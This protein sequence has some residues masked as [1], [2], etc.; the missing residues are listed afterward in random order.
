[1]GL[2]ALLERMERLRELVRMYL[3]PKPPPLGSQYVKPGT[4][5][6][7]IVMPPDPAQPSAFLFLQVPVGWFRVSAGTELEAGDIEYDFHTKK[8]VR[9]RAYVIPPGSSVGQVTASTFIIRRYHRPPNL[10]RFRAREVGEL[11]LEGDYQW[12]ETGWHFVEAPFAV[13]M[14]DI[15]F[16]K[17]EAARRETSDL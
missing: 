11:A 10:T 7:P 4:Y 15:V 5:T 6:Q 13:E 14:L 2:K 16:E 17:N 8:W 3:E 1:M 12:R 9:A